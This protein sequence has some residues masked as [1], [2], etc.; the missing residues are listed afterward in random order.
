MPCYNPLT[1]FYSRN[2]NSNGKRNIVFHSR[3]ALDDRSIKV[4]CGQCI[5]CKLERSRQWAMR[6]MHESTL[7]DKNCFITLTYSPE[8]LPEGGTLVKKDFQDFMKRLRFHN[9]HK[10]I[11]FFHCGEYGDQFQRPHYHAIIF[12]HDFDDKTPLKKINDNVIYESQTL[13]KLWTHGHCSTAAVTFDSAAYVA[14]YCTKKIT[15][16]AAFY[17][18]THFDADGEI[19]RELLPEYTTMSRRPGIGK[20]WL[21]KYMTDVYPDDFV[22]VRG[23]KL[24]PPKYYD[25]LLQDH[26]PFLVDE[27]KERRETRGRLNSKHT[28]PERLLVRETIQNLK[29]QT[30]KRTYEHDS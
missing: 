26:D 28:T 17:H 9:P 5:G 3:E 21:E 16:P 4:S 29:I 23:K 14:R 13:T 22:V 7:Y 6:C 2:L 8:N 18:Y 24:K 15:G 19:T 10:K 25:N 11:R 30:L 1:G 27:I 12:N 20:P